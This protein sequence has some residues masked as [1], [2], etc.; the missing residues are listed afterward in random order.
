MASEDLA[1]TLAAVLGGRGLRVQNY[2]SGPAGE[3][4]AQVRLRK[5]VCY[6]VLAVFLNEQDEVLLIQE[7]KKECRGSWYLPAGRMEPRETIVE[8]LQREVKEEAGLQCEPLTLLSVEERGPSWIRFV[9]L[10][11]PTGGILKTP[12]E[13]D[14]E[15]LQAGWYP[16]TSLPTPLRAHDILHL[17]ELAAQYRQRA[18]HPLL[19]PQELPC[20]LV[21]QRLVATFTSVQTVWVL[22]GTVGMPHLPITACGFAPIEQRGG[23][24][25]AV[26]RLLQE[27]LTLH[28]LAVE[29]KGLL[30]L[31][32]LGK[33]QADG[34]CLNVLV[35]VAFRNPG[36]QNE[37]PK[38][39]GENFFW[40]KV[41]EEDLQSQLLQRLQESSV[42]P[43]NR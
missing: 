14:A 9:F 28:H 43:I 2:D 33:D 23:I 11:R 16:R 34:I 26:L 25:M 7:A 4:P 22:V 40:W 15:S 18:G 36:I 21:C 35:T 32:H 31:Q 38:V 37:P 27:C 10:A 6:V 12:K 5:N 41:V 20:S 42:V 19:L 17:I 1:G 13:A 29:T 39:R 30:G 3:T 8:A 24:K